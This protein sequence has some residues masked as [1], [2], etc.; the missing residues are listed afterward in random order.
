MS[1]ENKNEAG[2]QQYQVHVSPDLDYCYR[3]VVNIY[4]GAGDVVFEYGYP[5]VPFLEVE[6]GV[7][8][9]V[10]RVDPGAEELFLSPRTL[11]VPP[12]CG[13]KSHDAFFSKK[14]AQRYGLH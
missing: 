14:L 3:D 7:Q 11:L 8:A 5:D 9:G 13:G 2:Q 4:V 1:E 10:V 12:D 6:Y